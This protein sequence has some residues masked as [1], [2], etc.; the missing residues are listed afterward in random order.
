MGG[1]DVAEVPSAQGP[2]VCAGLAGL[3]P[4]GAGFAAVTLP[5]LA[6]LLLAIGGDPRPL[7]VF[8]GNINQAGLYYPPDRALTMLLPTA[9]FWAGIWVC[10]RPPRSLP[11]WRLRWYLTAGTFL[12]LTEYPRLDLSHLAWS[13]PVLLVVGA[14][15]LEWPR[16]TP[17]GPL[18]GALAGPRRPLG[19][20]RGW[21]ARLIIPATLAV[22]VL[23]SLPI[24]QWRIGA[25][26]VPLVEVSGV[27]VLNG[28]WSDRET[29]DDL[30]QAVL[31]VRARTAPGEPI[32]VYPSSPL[33]YVA[34]ERPNPTRF[35][36][37][38]PGAATPQEIQALVATLDTSGIQTVVISDFWLEAWGPAGPNQ[39]L[40][41]YLD[42]SF[43]EVARHGVYRI[44]ETDSQPA[45]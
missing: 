9:A 27:P 18:L 21:A 35:D 12:F 7:G 24:L 20:C 38:Y 11:E 6:W 33:L 39:P 16:R 17:G 13:A 32:F 42:T 30:V 4:F 25:L 22:L 1:P 26:S 31:D 36:H 10:R 45:P 2:G 23:S 14:A 19:S 28:L 43:H 40:V 8:V 29:R 41:D 5:W 37:L 34:A 3:G 15:V 44:L